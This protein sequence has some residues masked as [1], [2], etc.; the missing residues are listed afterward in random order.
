MGYSCAT[1]IRSPKLRDEMMGFLKKN[2]RP[3]SVITAGTEHACPPEYDP[4][5]QRLCRDGKLDYDSGKCRIGFNYHSM[6]PGGLNDY[7]WGTLRWI[8]VRVGRRKSFA[9]RLPGKGAVPYT[10]YD[11]YE[12]WPVLARPEWDLRN[13][14]EDH[15]WC[16]VDSDGFKP[17][18]RYW[19]DRGFLSSLSAMVLGLN[20]EAD[21]NDKTVKAELARLSQLWDA[22]MDPPG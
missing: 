22:R 5:L 17:E 18:Q 1:P 3:W 20:Q 13:T 21:W 14:P 2:F 6:P 16:L 15:Q 12:A 11:G 19:A 10:V 4:T 7:V 8:A 9:K